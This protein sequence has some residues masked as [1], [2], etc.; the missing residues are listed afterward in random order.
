MKDVFQELKVLVGKGKV[1]LHKLTKIY[2][3]QYLQ[4]Q[5]RLVV[6]F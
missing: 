4:V 6:R 2:W 3:K 5:A 1:A